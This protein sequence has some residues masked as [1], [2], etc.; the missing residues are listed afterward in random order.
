[1]VIAAPF[2]QWED[3]WN[4]KRICLHLLGWMREKQAVL[5]SDLIN[6]ARQFTPVDADVAYQS[7]YGLW[8]N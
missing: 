1:M 4:V 2:V 7:S 5:D 3:K 6:I 8:E